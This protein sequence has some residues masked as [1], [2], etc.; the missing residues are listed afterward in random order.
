MKPPQ[1]EGN[2]FTEIEKQNSLAFSLQIEQKLHEEQTKHQ[3]IAIYATKNLGN[4]MV[5]NDTVLLV[6]K[7]CFIQHEMMAHPALF[8]H[9]RPQ[10]IAI[11]GHGE[12]G[13]LSEILKHP[14]VSEVWQIEKDQ[15][16]TE[17]AAQYFPDLCAQN[18]DPRVHFHFGEGSEWIA[19]SKPEYFDV[20]LI[21]YTTNVST[22]LF[23]EYLNALSPDG[24][25][26]QQSTS[27]RQLRI[28]KTTQQH[29]YDAGFRDVQCL[30]FPQSTLIPN[31]RTALFAKKQGVFKRVREKDIFNKPFT[32]RYYN[33][34]VHKAALVM[35]EFMREELIT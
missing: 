35:P 7:D 14:S 22:D 18:K 34:D 31:W 33:L 2:W 17:L 28:L 20:I 29:L 25:L 13:I 21:T 1:L 32:T 5:I 19:K 4:L 26:I 30:S 27:P 10:K 24:V 3:H 23:R 9:P 8:T 15:R 12:C 16:I 6:E 11:I